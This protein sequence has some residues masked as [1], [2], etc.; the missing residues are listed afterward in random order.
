MSIGR[1]YYVRLQALKI[2]SA[3][4]L[5][6]KKTRKRSVAGGGAPHGR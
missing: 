5:R 2:Q 1:D 6:Y 3:L 4:T